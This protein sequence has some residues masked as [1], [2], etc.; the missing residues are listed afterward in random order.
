MTNSKIRLIYLALISG[1]EGRMDWHKLDRSLRAQ[2]IEAD[3][4]M[5]II[6]ELDGEGLI[7]RNKEPDEYE[8]YSITPKGQALLD[9]HKK[10]S[11]RAIDR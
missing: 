9:A 10:V 5:E 4:L 2:K 7:F 6:G 1:Y 11:E 3:N 8:R